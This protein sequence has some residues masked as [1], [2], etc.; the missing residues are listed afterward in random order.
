MA[1]KPTSRHAEAGDNEAVE[2]KERKGL[3]SPEEDERLYTHI[4]RC[5]VST[6]SSVAQLAG[7]NLTASEPLLLIIN[8]RLRRSGKSCRLRWMNY[9][10][11]D[12]KKEPISDREAETIISLQKLLGNRWS[13]IAA[14]MPGRTDNE[15]KNYWN[16]RIR[17]RQIAAA[18]EV[19]GSSDGEPAPE[20]EKKP[21]GT[22]EATVAAASPP[23]TIPARLPVFA[24]QLPDGGAGT[25]GA[26]TQLPPA[27]EPLMNTGSESEVSGAKD[28]RDLSYSGGGADDSG[29]MIRHLLALDDL[30][31]PADLLIDVPGLLDAWDCEM[32]V[33]CTFE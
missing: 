4:T 28:S 3:W 19:T 26:A 16:S 30:E 1:R 17:K 9:L 8:H 22:N 6:W 27:T 5:G 24:F 18:G 32:Y 21:V 20:G 33:P 7:K 25:A 10:R 31:Y 23:M 12:L 14:N 2:A 13:V 29:D 15:I 11:P